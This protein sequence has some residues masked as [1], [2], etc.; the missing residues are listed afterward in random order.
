MGRKVF[1][2]DG[3]NDFEAYSADLPR[4]SINRRRIRS[5]ILF[6]IAMVAS[7]FVIGMLF[8]LVPDPPEENLLSEVEDFPEDHIWFNTGRPL[9]LYNELS[10]HVVVV[11]FCGLETLTEL[12]YFSRLQELQ[13]DLRSQPFA[14][15]VAL[16]TEESS[17]DELNDMI[18]DWG[19]EFPVIIDDRGEVSRR[20]RVSAFPGLLV[21]DARARV[22]ARFYMGWERTD[23]RGIVEDLLHQLRAMRYTDIEIFEP[24]GCCYIPQ[25]FSADR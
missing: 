25:R 16:Q 21:L 7:A 22:S 15:V 17:L 5:F 13:R 2:E 18:G 4:S 6:F 9:S 14:V 3:M 8:S 1:R 24:D 11:F 10:R 19:I 12:D 23:L 20:F